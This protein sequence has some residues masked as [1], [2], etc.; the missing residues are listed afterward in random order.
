M[1][2]R[3]KLILLFVATIVI[4]LTG[5]LIS[6]PSFYQRTMK[7]QI[8]DLAEGTLTAL[9]FNIAM[10]LDDLERL[11]VIP[12][13]NEDVMDALKYKTGY[14]QRGNDYE[15]MLAEKALF[16]SLPQQ[17][18]NL[19]K[20]IKGIVL[21]PFDGSVYMVTPY[22]VFNPSPDY[23]FTEQDWYR[24][25]IEAQ[26][27]VA[28]IGPHPLDYFP[29]GAMR[30]AFSVARLI[31]D[32]DSGK[33]LA[34][35][36]ADADTVVLE[37]IIKE[38]HFNVRST[39]AILDDNQ[40]LVYSN[41][42]ISE[43]VIRQLADGRGVVEE[44]AGNYAVVRNKLHKSG[45]SLAVLLSTDDIKSRVG[46]IYVAAYS[47]SFGGLLVTLLLYFTLSKWMIVPF[48][49]M[50]HVMKGVRRGDL[51]NRV[52]VRGSD[53]VAQLGHALNTMIVQLKELIDREYR[54]VIRER[55]AEY[56][57]LQ[58]QIQPHFLYNTL[59]GFIALNRMGHTGL[60]E[61]AIFSLSHM[62]RYTLEHKAWS[63]VRE[64]LLF[65]RQYCDL[66][67]LRFEE[68]L[69]VTIHADKAVES[70]LIPKLLLQPLVENA[71][72]H[73]LEPKHGPG[74]LQVKAE[75]PVTGA[76]PMLR[77]CIIDDGVGFERQPEREKRN[78]IG[79]KNVEERLRIAYPNAVFSLRSAAGEGTS[80]TI[81]I[82]MKDVKA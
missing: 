70:A 9:N 31:K 60:L 38:I 79:L 50:I 47:F 65:V 18:R 30:E 81:E 42:P 68:R 43:A 11:T 52:G 2:L 75:L 25:A 14:Q 80:I 73:G 82:P 46:W 3:S 63:T 56:Q 12:Y 61:D 77:I 44:P 22:A 27:K 67:R 35:M 5:I 20:D 74:H 34:V 62:M 64:E 57:A 53:E 1:R 76:E 19:R 16:F 59:N 48:K 36:M 7:A 29:D 66:Q 17:V 10:Y 33:P 23:P 32:P 21:L 37:N 55:E 45:W 8:T 78:S 58:S 26:G 39:V 71:I 51:Q 15:K 40:R 69:Q 72:I 49:E 4:P 6:V 28:F 24:K 13:M 41:N 54:A